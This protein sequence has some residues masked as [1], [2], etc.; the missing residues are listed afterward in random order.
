M[1]VLAAS[2]SR[3]CIGRLVSIVACIGVHMFVIIDAC[4]GVHM[5]VHLH[6]TSDSTPYTRRRRRGGDYGQI[7][8]RA[9][10]IAYLCVVVH[11]RLCARMFA[12]YPQAITAM[13][14][15]VRPEHPLLHACMHSCLCTN[16][17]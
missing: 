11:V 15:A 9:H 16:I 8:H 3:G 7:G 6:M 13:M 10:I 1:H 5:L 12:L 17:R 4:L 14:V 2:E